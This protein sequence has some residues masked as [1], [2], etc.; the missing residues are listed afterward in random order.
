MHWQTKFKN[1][2][3]GSPIKNSKIK[4]FL[5]ILVFGLSSHFCFSQ[6]ELAIFKHL[7]SKVWLAEGKW[8]D[9]STFKQ[10]STFSYA[11]DSTLVIVKSKGYINQ[12]KTEYG[13]RNHGI[14]KWDS[15]KGGLEFWEF[16]VFGEI[17]W[18]KVFVE[19]KN[20]RYEYVYEDT[21]VSDYWEYVDDDTYNFTIGNFANG[22]WEQVYLKTQF[23]VKKQEN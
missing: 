6:N 17:T 16:D 23:I 18:G 22:E 13:E 9:G 5:S 12:D 15:K 19:D 21:L 1:K 11:L 8:G 2:L 20:L 4:L 10:E 7:S 14:R 3:K